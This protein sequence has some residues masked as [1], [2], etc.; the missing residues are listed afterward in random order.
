MSIRD[1][2][3]FLVDAKAIVEAIKLGDQFNSTDNISVY[4]QT[5]FPDFFR[6]FGISLWDY[7]Q[8]NIT[9]SVT[10]SGRDIEQSYTVI[11]TIV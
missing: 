1:E 7:G 11:L 8:Y 9:G 6:I 3:G 5:G 2:K 4:K 10:T